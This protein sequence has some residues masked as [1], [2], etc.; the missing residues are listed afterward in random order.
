[1][2]LFCAL[3]AI[4]GMMPAYCHEIVDA[5]TEFGFQ[6]PWTALLLAT[7]MCFYGLGWYR[8]H[9]EGDA[10]RVLGKIRPLSFAA[11]ILILTIA[12][13]SPID[14]FAQYSFSMHM[15]Q[16]LLLMMAAPPLL[17]IG[18][19]VI[20]WLWAFPLEGRRR[21]G[22]AW[23]NTGVLRGTYDFLMRPLTVW[24]TASIALWFWHIPAAYDWALANERVHILEHL[25]FLMTSLAFWKLTLD[26]S[27]HVHGGYGTAMVMVITFALHSGLLGALLTFAQAPLYYADDRAYTVPMFGLSV[28]EDQQ[29]AGLLMWVPASAVYLVVLI[30]LLAGWMSQVKTGGRPHWLRGA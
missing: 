22:H 6:V 11:G 20:V 2:N 7:A 28:L 17:V 4:T 15:T 18:R 29:L 25:C 13:L 16:H 24:I 23:N 3:Y 27:L 26:P 1:M 5:A 10:V 12:L 9:S 19:P 14:Q 30:L 21:I 8:L